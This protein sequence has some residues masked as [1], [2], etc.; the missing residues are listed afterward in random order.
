MSRI[1][2]WLKRMITGIEFEMNKKFS[3]RCDCWECVGGGSVSDSGC[4]MV[5]LVRLDNN[6]LSQHLLFII[7]I[8]IVNNI[9]IVK[10]QFH[11]FHSIFRI[12]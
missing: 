5:A 10:V 12:H 8:I 6:K 7:I 9:I 2:L 11:D 3:Y 4:A 1:G